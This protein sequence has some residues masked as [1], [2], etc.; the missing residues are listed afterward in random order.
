MSATRRRVVVTGIGAVSPNGIG[1]EAFWNA[2]RRG[3]SG[4]CRIPRFDASRHQVQIAGEVTDFDESVYIEPK[5]RQHVSR[6]VPLAVA[7]AR[8][9]PPA[10]AHWASEPH[11]AAPHLV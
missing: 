2:T 7:A 1:R 11:S 4:V 9:W 6:A 3:Q 10:Q 8:E 5:D